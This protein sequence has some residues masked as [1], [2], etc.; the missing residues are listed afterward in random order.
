MQPDRMTVA[1]V[2]NG[3]RALS[4]PT[5]DG[6]FGALLFLS[7]ADMCIRTQRLWMRPPAGQQ[8]ENAESRFYRSASGSTA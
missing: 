2:C 5:A 7:D 1:P 3:G 8:K 4:L 6:V